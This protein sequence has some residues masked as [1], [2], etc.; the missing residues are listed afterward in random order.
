MGFI[1]KLI[2]LM[3]SPG[4]DTN[5]KEIAAGAL[6]PLISTEL[7]DTYVNY[8]EFEVMVRAASQYLSGTPAEIQG[9]LLVSK[10]ILTNF[11]NHCAIPEVLERLMPS[12]LA[13]A[14][15]A[16]R[17][18]TSALSSCN[19]ELA[20]E[21]TGVLL[22]WSQVLATVLEVWDNTSSKLI[23][24]IAKYT[25][26]AE[27][28]LHSLVIMVPAASTQHRLGPSHPT[29]A[30]PVQL[31]PL[32]NTTTESLLSFEGTSLSAKVNELKS[33]VLEMLGYLLKHFVESKKQTLEQ[34]GK[35]LNTMVLIG[36]PLP[37]SPFI[38]LL[39]LLV[40]PLIGSLVQVG[41][42]QGEVASQDAVQKFMLRGLS[43]LHRASREHRFYAPFN[44]L[45]RDFI[46]HS[47]LPILASS[48]DDLA[49]FEDSPEEFVAFSEEI[50]EIQEQETLKTKAAHLLE[51]L[52]EFVDGCLSF[53]AKVCL[54][55]LSLA[56]SNADVPTLMQFSGAKVLSLPKELCIDVGLLCLSVLNYDISTRKD[57]KAELE[58]TVEML[59]VSLESLQSDLVRT[60]FCLMLKYYSEYLFLFE[61]APKFNFLVQYLLSC[62]ESRCPA[63]SLQASSSLNH[64]M[65]EDELMFRIDDLAFDVIEC[66][67]QLIPKMHSK[68]FFESLEELVLKYT[69]HMRCFA[70]RLVSS[71][72]SRVL[73]EV[74][75]ATSKKDSIVLSKSLNVIRELAGLTELEVPLL[76]TIE[77]QA[78]G[79]MMLLRYPQA[80]SFEDDLLTMQ[81]SFIFKMQMV[82]ETGWQVFECLPKVFAKYKGQFLHL[83]PLLNVYISYG[84]STFSSNPQYVQTVLDMCHTCLFVTPDGKTSESV[85][86]EGALIYQLMLQLLREALDEHLSSILNSVL[87][88][89]STAVSSFFKARLLGVAMSAFSYNALLT[90]QVLSMSQQSADSS[91]LRYVLFEVFSNSYCFT[92]SYDKRVAVIGLCSLLTQETL[93]REVS[94]NLNAIFEIIITILS[95]KKEEPAVTA[96]TFTSLWTHM[97]GSVADDEMLACLAQVTRAQ[98]E[99]DYHS[100]ESQGNLALGRMLTPLHQ[101]DEYNHLKSILNSIRQRS[102]EALAKLIIPLSQGHREKLEQ[103]VQS[104]RVQVNHLGGENTTVRRKAKVKRVLSHGHYGHEDG[105]TI[106]PLL[107]RP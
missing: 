20:E 67:T 10:V 85:N 24:Q 59:F 21:A 30:V 66:Y 69:D 86:S 92:H 105:I 82:S 95:Q 28:F 72:V 51:S 58:S 32:D 4:L 100:E 99:Q 41:S 38:T 36:A 65:I 12:L 34:E 16:L 94:E 45:H 26:L 104:E 46:M 39:D 29:L 33:Y 1:E 102:P 3:G 71:L 97:A 19:A 55:M 84:V 103:I 54:E 50:C 74:P 2:G 13:V 98:L 49:S 40:K 87:T 14:D 9:G 73:Q 5:Q 80:I 70:S 27:I 31:S 37:A 93:A 8:F 91:Y 22:N 83:F 96:D 60:R 107:Q 47:L 56:W 35:A 23:K 89:Y 76:E 79:L 43:L 68:A 52:C 90:M 25:G 75:T 7:T 6:L 106:R 77:S 48:A 42:L 18:T 101:V 78:E 11:P 57:I 61:Q 44:E 63:L 15:K 17:Q 53:S 81:R 62:M 64:I 88:R